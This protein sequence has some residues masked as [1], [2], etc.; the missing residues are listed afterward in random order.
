[1]KNEQ[2]ELPNTDTESLVDESTLTLGV[3]LKKARENKGATVEDIAAQLHLRPAIVKEIEADNLI[4]IGAATYV[5]GYVKNYARAVQADPFVVQACLDKQ[6]LNDVQPSMQS[7]SRKTTHQARDGRLMF[8]TYF[9]VFVLLALMVMW[10]FQ[11]SSMETTV[12]YSQPT[13]EEVA[14][15][16]EVALSLEQAA[17]AAAAVERA[18][19]NSIDAN[20]TETTEVTDFKPSIEPAASSVVTEAVIT[21]AL[22]TAN[23]PGTSEETTL[24]VNQPV[25]ET[26][27]E[28]VSEPVA[29]EASTNIAT[30]NPDAV[31]SSISINLSGDC[32]I[33]LTDATGKALINGLKV[34]GRNINVSGVEPFSVI[35]GA[36]QVVSMQFNG[37]PISLAKYPSSKVARF[38]LPLATQ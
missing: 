10:W 28:T 31:M 26:A 29:R 15:S 25:I 35:L 34:S 6:L 22:T 30:N 16:A 8:L 2:N 21:P 14:A 9:I 37:S 11:K 12:D 18:T 19:D 38:S 7:F 27:T 20:V 32:W 33:K 5:R 1:M 3:L 4:E 23:T 17:I 24:S 36:P 13:A